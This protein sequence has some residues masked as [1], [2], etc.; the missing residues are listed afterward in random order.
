M[1]DIADETWLEEQRK[2]AVSYLEKQGIARPELGDDPAFDVSPYVS[3]WAVRSRKNPDA[4]GW[5]VIAG[6]LPTDYISASDAKEPRAAIAAFARLWKEAADCMLRG[7]DHPEFSVGG[8]DERCGL[9]DLLGRRSGV[10]KS[11]SENEDL[12]KEED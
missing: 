4:V 5:W 3:L 7:E 8:P 9:G 10:L 12:W 11:Y 1:P 6:D 2:V